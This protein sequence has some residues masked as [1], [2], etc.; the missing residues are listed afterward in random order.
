MS[1]RNRPRWSQ[2]PLRSSLTRW[3]VRATSAGPPVDTGH[4]RSAAVFRDHAASARAVGFAGSALIAVGGLGA[5]ALPVGVAVLRRRWQRAG[6]FW[7]AS[8]ADWRCCCPAGDGMAGPASATVWTRARSPSW[9][10]W[11]SGRPGQ[12]QRWSGQPGAA[13]AGLCRPAR[14]SGRPLGRRP[15]RPGRR[16]QADPGDLHQLSAADPAVPGGGDRV[17]P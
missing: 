16:D 4:G 6:R 15:H 9:P 12:V 2:A 3:F 17:S 10:S 8:T 5:G 13:G 14:R 1:V 11:C 7:W